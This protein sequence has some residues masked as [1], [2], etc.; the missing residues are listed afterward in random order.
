L[1]REASRQRSDASKASRRSVSADA[2]CGEPAE[3]FAFPEESCS[4]RVIAPIPGSEHFRFGD[5]PGWPSSNRKYRDGGRRLTAAWSFALGTPSWIGTTSRTRPSTAIEHISEPPAGSSP[6]CRHLLT[7]AVNDSES[8]QQ[9][10]R[11]SRASPWRRRAHRRRVQGHPRALP[12]GGPA[13]EAQ[14]G[15]GRCRHQDGADRVHRGEFL[16]D[17]IPP[18]EAGSCEG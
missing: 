6:I 11:S 4:V 7:R 17:V 8:R 10:A 1:G 13:A 14:A 12:G 18:G 2:R 16:F 3:L 15:G 5:G 9:A